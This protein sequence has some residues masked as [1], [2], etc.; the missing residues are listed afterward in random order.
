MPIP[1][2]PLKPNQME[3][4]TPETDAAESFSGKPMAGYLDDAFELCRRLER[5]RDDARAAIRSAFNRCPF[6]CDSE[7]YCGTCAIL[8]PFLDKSKP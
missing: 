4:D 3:T 2:N 8:L 5:E 7:S 1:C 6:N